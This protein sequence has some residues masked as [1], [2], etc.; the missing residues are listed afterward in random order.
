[1]KKLKNIVLIVLCFTCIIIY[2]QNAK[3]TDLSNED[4]IVII[5]IYESPILKP[6]KTIN[7]RKGETIKWWIPSKEDAGLEGS[8]EWTF[9]GWYL[10]DFETPVN[11]STI[12]WEDSSIYASWERFPEEHQVIEGGL[13][14][15]E[16]E[17]IDDIFLHNLNNSRPNIIK[18]KNLKGKKIQFII[19]NKVK[20]DKYEIRFSPNKKF[21]KMQGFTSSVE[22]KKIII[23]KMRRGK[24]YYIKVRGYKINNGKKYYT[25]WSKVKSVKIKK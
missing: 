13:P 12:F 22:E 1:M 3:A 20:V 7:I 8:E 15:Y 10:E 18:L 4:N 24:T 6:T 9:M 5:T 2:C 23:K 21:K 19:N 16:D 17:G 14:E 25:K 11:D